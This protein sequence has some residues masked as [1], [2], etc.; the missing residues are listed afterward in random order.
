[1]TDEE[2][3]NAYLKEETTYYQ[4]FYCSKI[5]GSEQ[6]RE[7]HIYEN[8]IDVV[9]Q[10][11]QEISELAQEPEHK[12]TIQEWKNEKTKELLLKISREN[13]KLLHEL[14]GTHG[15]EILEKMLSEELFKMALR[16]ETLS[17]FDAMWLKHP[18]FEEIKAEKDNEK[19]E[20]ILETNATEED[21][22]DKRKKREL[23]MILTSLMRKKKE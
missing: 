6:E 11:L 1:M 14:Q 3:L 9:E 2:N 12:Q 17:S 5:F 4:C 18:K 23:V 22:E 7:T 8:H 10:K 15:D 20:R 16:T 13:P 21:T 19:Q